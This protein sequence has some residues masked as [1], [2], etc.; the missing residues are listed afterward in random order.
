MRNIPEKLM[1]RAIFRTLVGLCGLN[2]K[3]IRRI[4]RKRN[5]IRS[6]MLRYRRRKA[7]REGWAWWR[8]RSLLGLRHGESSSSACGSAST[9]SMHA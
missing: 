3:K 4:R 6:Q 1:K 9:F 8:W 7:G 5:G 2:E